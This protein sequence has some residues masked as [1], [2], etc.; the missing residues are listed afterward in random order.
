MTSAVASQLVGDRVGDAH[1]HAA[2]E[3][4]GQLAGAGVAQ[5]LLDVGEGHD[6]HRAQRL[7]AG[8]LAAEREH[9]VA[10][11]LADVGGR[12]EVDG[13]ERQPAL[14]R[15]PAGDR[16]VDAARE[17][18]QRAPRRR[19]PAARRARRACRR[20][21]RRGRWRPRCRSS[22]PACGRRRGGR[23]PSGR[24]RRPGARSP[25]TCTGKRLSPRRDSTLK[26]DRA[27]AARWPP[28][29]PRPRRRRSPPARRRR[30]PAARRRTTPGRRRAPGARRRRRRRPGGRAP[31]CG[32]GCSARSAPGEIGDGAR[33]CCRTARARSDGG[34]RSSRKARRSGRG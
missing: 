12:M 18:Q 21:R 31:G 19:R 25:A 34:C 28:R 11:L 13:V 4:H 15:Q 14:G 5:A 29:P 3:D 20:R 33:G 6:R 16:R 1:H 30:R 22:A 7:P 8:Q 24:A 26:R 10:R 2:V 23:S 32:R 9:L 17:Q 27:I